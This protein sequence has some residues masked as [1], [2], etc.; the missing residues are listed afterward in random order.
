MFEIINSIITNNLSDN[1]H[2]LYSLLQRQELFKKFR[3]EIQYS[4]LIENLD[5]IFTHF[6]SR[7][8]KV[9]QGEL[10]P[11]KVLLIIKETLSTWDPKKLTVIRLI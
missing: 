8:I 2:F 1:P 9:D 6:Q 3:L 10:T 7:I 5:L 4:D 11:D